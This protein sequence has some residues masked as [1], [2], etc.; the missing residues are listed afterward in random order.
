MTLSSR[1]SEAQK[2]GQAARGRVHLQTEKE[3]KVVEQEAFEIRPFCHVSQIQG[4]QL[5]KYFFNQ[6]M[7]TLIVYRERE[8]RVRLYLGFNL[9]QFLPALNGSSEMCLLFCSIVHIS[10]F[11]LSFFPSLS[12]CLTFFVFILFQP[13]CL[14]FSICLILLTMRDQGQACNL[15][16]RKRALLV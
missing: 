8:K 10:C 11:S 2:D 9:V 6:R 16:P 4:A 14:Y 5:Q 15:H 13:F 1:A 7:Q 3:L 12:F